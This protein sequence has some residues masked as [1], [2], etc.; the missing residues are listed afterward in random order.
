MKRRQTEADTKPPGV[1][2]GV[3]VGNTQPEL[4]AEQQASLTSKMGPQ[5]A[6]AHALGQQQ[7]ARALRPAPR[8][9]LPPAYVQLN[10]PV[11][12]RGSHKPISP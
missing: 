5:K 4:Q 7:K 6:E 1:C 3:C 2:W 11:Q 10:P 9:H 12:S 8:L